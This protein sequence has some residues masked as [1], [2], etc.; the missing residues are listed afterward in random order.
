MQFA[1]ITLL[2]V[3]LTIASAL[4]AQQAAPA[5][6][7]QPPPPQNSVSSAPQNPD[8]HVRISGGVML[9]QRRT[10]VA[11]VYP[12]EARATGQEGTVVLKVTVGPDGTAEEATAISGPDVFRQPAIDAVKQWT[13]NPYSV[14]HR[15]VKVDTTVTVN[16]RR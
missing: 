13:W 14:N 6:Q 5:I 8:R 7:V 16:F 2:T 9:T 4:P 15:P 11:P 10:Y 3:A 12:E 1:R